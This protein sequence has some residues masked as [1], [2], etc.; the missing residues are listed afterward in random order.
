M[1][2]IASRRALLLVNHCSRRGAAAAETVFE[3]LQRA[4]LEVLEDA[5]CNGESLADL[6]RR[7]KDRVDLIV[8]GGGDGTLNAALDGLID[9]GLPV[10]ILPLGTA[11]DLAR[12]L[13]L[14]TDL[15]EAC[16]LI[17]AGNTRRID[18]GQVNG[19][20]FFNVAS[21]GLS[22]QITRELTG[23]VKQAWGVLAYLKTALSVLFRSR[24]FHAEI[25]TAEQSFR[26]KTVQIAVGN[27]RHYGGGMTVSED[28]AI[29]DRRLD[30]YSIE[31]SH[32]WQILL[33]LPRLKTGSL[34][35]SKH[36]RTLRGKSF[37]I[38][39]RRTR[40]VNTDGEITTRTPAT[41]GLRPAA[42]SVFVPAD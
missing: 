37:E 3:F 17:A 35:N 11:N 7:H 31:I 9:A 22:V 2:T 25:R 41:F 6:V 42:L 34:A 15:A 36:V 12:T 14:P 26:V 27:G 13:G 32:F 10:G 39:T 18:V 16:E 4:G 30:L 33:L 28:A 1:T 40:S 38:I 23:E 8:V 19:K 21:I 5:P 20:C 29:D 24:L